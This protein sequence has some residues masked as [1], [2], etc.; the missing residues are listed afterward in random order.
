MGQSDCLEAHCFQ[1]RCFF[2]HLSRAWGGGIASVE[3]VMLA[4]AQTALAGRVHERKTA[5]VTTRRYSPGTSMP[6]LPAS[7]H[8]GK[9]KERLMWD[10]PGNRRTNVFCST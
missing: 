1:T 6:S 8:G 3:G 4:A 10:V 9:K 7:V 2:A 5:K